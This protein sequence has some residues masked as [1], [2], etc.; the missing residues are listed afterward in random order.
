MH[1]A[2]VEGVHKKAQ[3]I[4]QYDNI[5]KELEKQLGENNE[6]DRNSEVEGQG[7]YMTQIIA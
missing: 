7:F 4:K 3:L 6:N 5:L 1:K 2:K